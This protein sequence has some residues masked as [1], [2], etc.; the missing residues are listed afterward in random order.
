MSANEPDDG[1]VE[2]GDY[3]MAPERPRGLGW[4]T[5]WL[6]DIVMVA[7]LDAAI[8]QER[9]RRWLRLNGFRPSRPLPRFL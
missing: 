9:R 4:V 3:D 6:E 8:E 7:C 1:E 5:H 2:W